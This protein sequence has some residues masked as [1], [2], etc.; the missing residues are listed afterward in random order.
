MLGIFSKEKRKNV[1]HNV[2]ESGARKS[3]SV[4]KNDDTQILTH[5]FYENSTKTFFMGIHQ[6]RKVWKIS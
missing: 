5:I 4:Q 1:E 3:V 6:K 2:L